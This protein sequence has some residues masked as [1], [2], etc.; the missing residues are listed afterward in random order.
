MSSSASSF[1]GASV[2]QA[3]A[4]SLSLLLARGARAGER[5]LL[6]FLHTAVKQRAL[7]SELGAALPGI[8]V[9]AV[10]RVADFERALRAGQ[11]AVLT[12]PA[13]LSAHGLEPKLRGRRLG[14]AEEKYCLIAADVPPDPARVSS[15]GALD[16]LGREGTT[17]FVHR[18]VPSRPRVE[19]V[20]KVED[21]LPLLQLQRV[22]AI[23]LPSRFYREIHTLSR[24]K[25]AQRELTPL[26]GLPAVSG[27]GPAANEVIA[28]VRRLPSGVTAPFGVDEWH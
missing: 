5:R 10:G 20:A 1:G 14:S 11:D 8:V 24:L 9:T 25:L 21:L 3:V 13:V 6:A 19:R 12:L 27:T 15:V 7:Q 18:L 17:A 28:A 4:L 26:V 2:A 23:L 16:I 22:A